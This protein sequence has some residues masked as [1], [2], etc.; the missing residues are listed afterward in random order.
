MIST[1]CTNTMIVEDHDLTALGVCEVLGTIPIVQVVAKARNADEAQ[2][3]AGSKKI[4]LVIMDIRL[5]GGLDG[6]SLAS[7]LMKRNKDL[8]ILIHSSDNNVE[9]VRRANVAGVR[10]YVP[11]GAGIEQFKKAIEIIIAGGSYI[12]PSLPKPQQE[13]ESLT[14]REMEV[15]K[16]IAEGK[17]DDEIGLELKIKPVTV[18]TFTSS[19]RGKRVLKGAVELYIY[20][21]DIFPNLK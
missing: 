16:L 20:A 13:T 12:D 18:R 9:L 4:D 19:I 14:S 1:V 10:G 17:D 21:K 7:E 5:G 8:A 15:L 2:I 3:A 11:K 6:I